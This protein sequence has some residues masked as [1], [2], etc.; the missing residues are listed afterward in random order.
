MKIAVLREA[1]GEPRVAAIPETV[2]KFIALGAEVAVESGAGEKAGV[3]DEDYQAAGAGVAGRAAAMKGA[4]IILCVAGPDP[5]TLKG[6]AKGAL[7][8]G[9]LDPSR[10]EA[11]IA[12]YAK[13]GLDP[14]AMERMP[15]ITR[16]QSMD[17]LSSQSNLAGYKAVIDAAGAYGRA[18][19]MMMTAAGTVSAARVFVMGVGVAGLQAIATARRL[20]AQV[21]AT[22]VRSATR[23]QIQSLGAKPIFVEG[24]AGIEGEGQ[25]GY[26]SETSPEYQKAQAELVSGHIAKQDIV[27]TTALI[28]GRPAPRLISDAQLASMRPGSVVV[29]LAAEAGGNVEGVEAGKSVVRHGVTIIGAVQL[30]RTLAPDSSALF[31]RNLFNFLSAF[32]DAETRR[33][34]LP[35][36]DEIVKALRVAP[37]PEV[38]A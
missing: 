3:T 22:D 4:G 33:P 32:W 20:G 19:P 30:A 16:A 13:A 38:V 8:V 27:I 14:L 34:V 9:G 6:A 37:A 24:V 23:E 12:A 36:D 5:A 18:F 2:K 26:A 35:A 7:L 10:R 1:A 25:G 11:D 17:I 15:R 28:P 29:D 31:A 21:S